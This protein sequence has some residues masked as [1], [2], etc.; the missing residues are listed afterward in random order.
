MGNLWSAQN[1]AICYDKANKTLI[2]VPP[3]NSPYYVTPFSIAGEQD[4]EF[5]KFK[6]QCSAKT[7]TP[8]PCC[9]KDLLSTMEPPAGS[10]NIYGKELPNGSFE[11]CP[12]VDQGCNP[13]S[14]TCREPQVCPGMGYKPLSAYQLCKN[15]GYS[16]EIKVAFDNLGY[17][18][19]R[20]F[21][22]DVTNTTS[23]GNTT[24][25]NNTTSSGSAALD[26]AT[27]EAKAKTDK[28]AAD[29]LAAD[30]AADKAAP[31]AAGPSNGMIAVY[32]LIAVGGCILLL[33]A[34][35]GIFR[36]KAPS[37]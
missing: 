21:G 34:A 4:L 3:E 23:S 18:D 32:T 25:N 36:K 12:F 35:Y 24:S 6:Q 33:L 9:D 16:P 5:V 1:Q 26:K 14:L 8:I 30:K 11:M 27:A 10:R 20:G 17:T 22:V 37:K 28:A 29:K 7:G 13:Q 31:A 2:D 19:C 15:K